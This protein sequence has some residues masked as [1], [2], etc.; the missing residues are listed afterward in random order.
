MIRFGT[1]DST[2]EEA[3]RRAVAGEPGRLWIVAEEQSAGRGRRGRNWV[4]PHGNLYASALLIHPCAPA[5]APQLGF[6]A[7]LALAKAAAD[8]GASGLGLKWPNDLMCGEAKCAGLLVEG[9]SLPDRRLACVVGIGVNCR[10]APDGVGYATARL[11]DRRGRA[12]G[13]DELFERLVA[14]FDEALDQ[15]RAGDGFEAIR[16][17]WLDRAA[18]LGRRIRIENSAGR[19]EG[20]F[21]GLDAGGRLLFRGARGAL[22]AIETADLWILPAPDGPP[23]AAPSASLAR[24]GRI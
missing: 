21:E 2:N 18:G 1:I 13:A 23:L 15:W 14:R 9:V 20:V 5:I 11:T 22:E 24:E 12:V 7:G 17:A 6:V 10:V 19:R 3:R 4:S 16:S 8:A